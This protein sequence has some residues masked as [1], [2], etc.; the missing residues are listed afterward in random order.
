M[1][2]IFRVPVRLSLNTYGQRVLVIVKL[3]N[4]GVYFPA[5]FLMD[6]FGNPIDGFRRWGIL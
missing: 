3:V 4:R 1:P 5:R 2:V 6:R